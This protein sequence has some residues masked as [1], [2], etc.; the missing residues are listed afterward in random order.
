M[1]P[2]FLLLGG[3]LLFFFICD[4]VIQGIRIWEASKEPQNRRLT[5]QEREERWGPTQ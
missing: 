2:Y 5:P 3:V 4:L 1:L